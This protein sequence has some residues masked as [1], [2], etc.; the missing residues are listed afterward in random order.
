LAASTPN[1]SK[2]TGALKEIEITPKS[3]LPQPSES[4]II[5]QSIMNTQRE[6]DTK[7]QLLEAIQRANFYQKNAEWLE[8]ENQQLK[9]KIKSEIVSMRKQNYESQTQFKQLES[10]NKALSQQL[11]SLQKR[12]DSLLEKNSKCATQ[13]GQLESTNNTLTQKLSNHEKRYNSLR[14]ENSKNF[15][16]W[17]QLESVNKKLSQ[18]LSSQERRY[19]SLQEE[20]N[21]TA[22]QTNRLS[23]ERTQFLNDYRKLEN[24]TDR[25]QG[26]FEHLKKD[27]EEIRRRC[28]VIDNDNNL[29]RGQITSMSSA[30]EP[31]HGEEFYIS[32]FEQIKADVESFVAKETRGQT[33]GKFPGSFSE[34]VLQRIRWI[35]TKVGS[36]AEVKIN[37]FIMELGTLH[38]NRRSQIALTRYAIALVLNSILLSFTFGLI[39][40]SSQYLQLIE[41]GLCDNEGFLSQLPD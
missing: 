7:M 22:T 25:L 37:E 32:N 2:A 6:P 20:S 3:T 21:K 5:E 18:Q 33:E 10:E 24:E 9:A 34:R 17:K 12:C 27:H 1:T 35:L 36:L 39:R 19:E 31:I 41:N 14:E 29:L 40:E 15:T 8:G 4:I 28:A 13:C 38:E 26:Q 11:F 23:N 16:Q 30:Q